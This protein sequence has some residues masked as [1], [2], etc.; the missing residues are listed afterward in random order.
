MKF[1]GNTPQPGP[2][3][4]G[5]PAH[6]RPIDI[7]GVGP[8]NQIGMY[9]SSNYEALQVK[10]QKRFSG[11]LQLAAYY[12]Y[13]KQMD[14]AG[15]S[16]GL[17]RTPQ[18]PYNWGADWASGNYDIR[19]SFK[20]SYVYQLPF[21]RG[22]RWLADSNG[23][24]DAILGGWNVSGISTYSTGVPVNVTIAFDNANIGTNSQRP[25]YIPGFPARVISPTD[26][27]HGWLNPASY[28]VAPQYTFGDLGRNSARAPGVENW[29]LAV[30]K[31]FDIHEGL[32][33]Q[34]RVEAFNLF[35]HTNFGAP[36]GTFG[37]SSFGIISNAADPRLGQV[38][39]K[40]V[41]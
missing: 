33:C 36:N 26:K 6:P 20:A 30:Y 23:V 28:M 22:K 2:G 1:N 18:N 7:P 3:T 34:F 24:I 11:G 25:D 21:G 19:I 40:F 41:F 32:Y 9:G 17:T 27:T 35:N 38:G 4:I 14:L 15:S 5:S 29:D 10:F 13:A 8:L 37:T 39:L 16:F 12:V 31:N